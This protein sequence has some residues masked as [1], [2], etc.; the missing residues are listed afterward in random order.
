MSDPVS[1]G[2]GDCSRVQV[3]F[4]LAWYLITINQ[5][6]QLSLAIPVVKSHPAVSTSIID[7]VR[8]RRPD[9]VMLK[10]WKT[11]RFKFAMLSL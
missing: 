9:I 3:A 10:C 7:T 5:P 8:S 11:D 1:S 6:G 4:A 2:M